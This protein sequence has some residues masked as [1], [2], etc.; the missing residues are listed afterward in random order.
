[1]AKAATITISD[2][3]QEYFPRADEGLGT[4]YERFI[5]HNYFDLLK[6][7]YGIRSV[8]EAPSFG[9]TGVSGVNSMWWASKEAKVSIVDQSATR[10][11]AIQKVWSDTG[12]SAEFVYQA[13]DSAVLPFADGSFDMAWN[14]AALWHVKDGET[15][16]KE[17][18]RV[19]SKALFI[20]VPNKQNVCWVLRPHNSHDYELKNI[21]IDWITSCL[22]ASQWRLVE[23]GFFDVPPW[24]DIAMKK[25]NIFKLVGLDRLAKSKESGKT[26]G[27]CI[28]DYFNGRSP[29]MGKDIMKYGFLEHSPNW[30]KQRWAH[31]RFLVF[32]KE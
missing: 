2:C 22:E 3:W 5:L 29:A 10:L 27:L 23:T 32:E 18:A 17:L 7:R 28:L 19:A 31:H 21:R 16:L 14:F 4:I 25:E 13:S 9:M 26:E 15:Y 24:P 1:L 12:L 11:N 30:L 6:T 20:C 8:L